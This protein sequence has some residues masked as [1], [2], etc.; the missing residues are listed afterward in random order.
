VSDPALIRQVEQAAMWAWPPAELRS[1]HGW[2]VSLGG[3]GTRRLRSVRTLDFEPNTDIGRAIA[4]A[5]AILAARGWPSCFHITDRV[6]PVDLDGRL[7]ARGYEVVTPTEVMLA[8]AAPPGRVDE[9]IELH[10]RASQAVMNAICDRHWTPAM[11]LERSEIFAR[12]RRPHRFALAW[13]DGQPAGAG[14]GVREGDLAG[15]FAMRTQP[16]FRGRGMA[17]RILDR[18]IGWAAGEG[19]GRIYLQVEE[20]N[21]PALALYRRAGFRRAYGYHY[22]E[23]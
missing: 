5:E 9:T 6:E 14:L 20:D 21:E 3:P 18:L 17:S 8:G 4:E 12:I 7:E 19:A 23:R 22:R 1:I 16:A 11:R 10:T 15:I 2:L 13:Q